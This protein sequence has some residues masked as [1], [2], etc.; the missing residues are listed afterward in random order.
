MAEQAECVLL[1]LC[2]LHSILFHTN[3]DI[4]KLIQEFNILIKIQNTHTRTAENNVTFAMLSFHGWQSW[5]QIFL[6]SG[7]VDHFYAQLS[8]CASSFCHVSTSDFL[9][10]KQKLHSNYSSLKK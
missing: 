5:H 8:T 6:K 3:A 9:S 4:F 7:R 10:F 2:D 1:I